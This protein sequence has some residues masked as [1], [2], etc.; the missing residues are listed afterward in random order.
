MWIIDELENQILGYKSPLYGRK[1]AQFKVLPFN[2]FESKQFLK[3]FKLE[4]QAIL[5]GITGGIP[6]YLNSDIDNKLSVKSNITN[7]FLTPSGNFYE[8]PL[9]LIKQELREPSTYNGIIEAIAEGSIRLNEIAVKGGK[10]EGNKCAKYL[11]S[12][13]D[14]GIIKKAFID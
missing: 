2:F 12:L 1:T 5:Y 8:E 4:D 7:L 14:L 9:N 3:N 11:R 10:L 13:I 6:E